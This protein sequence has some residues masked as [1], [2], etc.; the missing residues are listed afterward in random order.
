MARRGLRTLA[1]TA[2]AA[3]GSLY[4]LK[5]REVAYS[6]VGVA[7]LSDEVPSRSMQSGVLKGSSPVRSV[8]IMSAHH[9]TLHVHLYLLRD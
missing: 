4:I 3:G 1:L 9:L 2:A 8:L 6:D 5:A 7:S